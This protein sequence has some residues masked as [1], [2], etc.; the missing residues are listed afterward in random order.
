MLK[1][2]SWFLVRELQSGL[3]PVRT[4]HLFTAAVVG[5]GQGRVNLNPPSCHREWIIWWLSFNL[6]LKLVTRYN[7]HQTQITKTVSLILGFSSSRLSCF[8]VVVW[9][10]SY[11]DMTQET[12]LKPNYF[13]VKVGSFHFILVRCFYYRHTCSISSGGRAL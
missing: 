9:L 11:Q 2:L 7:L 3:S 5:F 8:V 12:F 4:Q 6:L 13:D 1:V 10:A